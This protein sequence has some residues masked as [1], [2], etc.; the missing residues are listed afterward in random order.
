MTATAIVL[1]YLE[2]KI[3]ITDVLNSN[4]CECICYSFTLKIFK[5][6]IFWMNEIFLNAGNTLSQKYRNSKNVCYYI[7]A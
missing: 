7:K 6:S 3:N 4:N 2:F 1:V 5:Y